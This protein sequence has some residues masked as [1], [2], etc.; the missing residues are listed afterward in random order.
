MATAVLPSS[1]QHYNSLPSIMDTDSKPADIAPLTTTIRQ[2]FVKHK[3]QKLFGINLLHSHCS[4]RTKFS[5][6]LD[7]WLCLERLR[8]LRNSSATSEAMHDVSQSGEYLYTN[9]PTASPRN[10]ISAAFSH[11]YLN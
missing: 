11:S 9:L 4:L 6:T 1:V 8:V 2:V 5:S 7:L 10:L 3:V